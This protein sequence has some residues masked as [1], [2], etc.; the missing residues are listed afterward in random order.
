MEVVHLLTLVGYKALNK[1]RTKDK[2]TAFRINFVFNRL[3]A[4]AEFVW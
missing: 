3:K 4:K 2:K 1:V